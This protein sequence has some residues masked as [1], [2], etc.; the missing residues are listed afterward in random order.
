MHGLSKY[1]RI[2]QEFLQE[3]AYGISAGWQKDKS[4]TSA[5]AKL[6]GESVREKV[7]KKLNPKKEEI[8]SNAKV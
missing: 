5:L 3:T 7:N 6:K 2:F 8:I 1:M 4:Y